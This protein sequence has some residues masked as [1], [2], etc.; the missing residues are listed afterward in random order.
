MCGFVS[1]AVLHMSSAHPHT[2]T[3]LSGL[4]SGMRVN[5][6]LTGT[7]DCAIVGPLGDRLESQSC[8]E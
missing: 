5:K 4:F 7:W 6:L 1:V 8:Q 2:H 3:G